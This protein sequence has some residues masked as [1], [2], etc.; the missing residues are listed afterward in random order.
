MNLPFVKKETPIEQEMRELSEAW[1]MEDLDSTERQEL[2]NRYMEL[3]NFKLEQDKLK[4]EHGITPARVLSTA[5]TVGLAVMTLNFEEFS[6]LKSKV[7]S[8]WLRRQ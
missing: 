5:T 4:L 2:I 3:A 8:M 7:T 1:V 6:I